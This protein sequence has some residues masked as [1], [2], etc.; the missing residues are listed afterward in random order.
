[1]LNNLWQKLFGSPDNNTTDKKNDNN[2]SLPDGA[3][4][5]GFIITEDNV[6]AFARLDND[7]IL[8]PML[9]DICQDLVDSQLGSVLINHLTHSYIQEHPEH[10]E[11]IGNTLLELKKQIVEEVSTEDVI[12]PID[13]FSI[14]EE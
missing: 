5:F 10:T 3:I 4:S 6:K 14:D 8:E 13:V 9:F 2:V 7:E 1:M 12:S 11:I